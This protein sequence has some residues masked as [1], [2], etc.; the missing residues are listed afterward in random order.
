[1]QEQRGYTYMKRTSKNITIDTI[2]FIGFVLLTTTGI[3]MRYVLPPGSGR[4]KV[5]WGLDRHG[6]GSIHFWI[7]ILFLSILTIH[8]VLHWRW[9][10]TVLTGRPREGSGLRAGLGIV[11]L[12][13]LLALSAAPLLSPI[14]TVPGS[15]GRGATLIQEHEEIQIWGSMTLHEIEQ[16]SGVPAEYILLKLGLPPDTPVDERLGYL[17]KTHGFTMDTVRSIVSNYKAE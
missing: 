14:E 7:S 13:G 16:T 8:L 10:V 2:A 5:I 1:M 15:E 12:A 11:G 3:L 9:I 17:K 4:F 6:W